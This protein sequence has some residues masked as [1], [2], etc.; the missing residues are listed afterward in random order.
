M[1]IRCARRWRIRW[2]N[3]GVRSAL[4]LAAKL[5]SFPLSAAKILINGGLVFQ[6]QGDGRVDAFER[7]GR[8]TILNL[9][10]CRPLIELIDNGVPRDARANDADCATL[11]FK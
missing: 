4:Q 10:R 1:Q 6:I 7:E 9:F 3:S 2:R 8:E 5:F 11:V